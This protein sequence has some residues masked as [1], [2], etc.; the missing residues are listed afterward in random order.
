MTRHSDRQLLQPLRRLSQREARTGE[1]QRREDQGLIAFYHVH[2]FVVRGCRLVKSRSDGTHFYR[3]KQGHFTDNRVYTAQMGGYFIE[4]CEDV[5]AT[6]N[7]IRDNGSPASP[8]SAA[9]ATARSSATWWPPAAAEGCRRPTAPALVITGNVFHHNG[10]KPNGT[11][12]HQHLERQHHRQRRPVRP[13]QIADRRLSDRQHPPAPR[14]QPD[15]P[16]SASTPART[17]RA[18]WSATTCCAART[19]GY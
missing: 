1:G 2:D 15:S 3:C 9:R 7:V 6:G 4:I 13:H 14:R 19:G 12:A 10:R 18:L 8:S 17:R 16:P 11:K 5:T